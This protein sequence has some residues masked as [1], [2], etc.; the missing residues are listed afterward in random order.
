M[1]A[2]TNPKLVAAKRH[3]GRSRQGHLITECITGT[4]DYETAKTDIERHGVLLQWVLEQV[5]LIEAELSE[6][7][8]ARMRDVAR[9]GD[10]DAIK[11][12]KSQRI[13]VPQ[14]EGGMTKARTQVAGLGL[15]HKQKGDLSVVTTMTQPMMNGL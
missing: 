5:P 3:L 15:L 11:T 6:S 14:S 1:L 7:R 8:A 10:L 4:W 13:E 9:R 2:I 12:T